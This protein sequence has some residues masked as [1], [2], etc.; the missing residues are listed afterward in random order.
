MKALI[1]GASSGIG[2]DMA[3]ILSRRGY[4]L[5]LVA[6]RRDRLEELQQQ[7]P[8][9]V[10]V[11][12]ADLSQEQACFDLYEQ[13]KNERIHILINNAGF[14]LF[15]SFAE[16]DLHR[17]LE[18]IDVNIRAVHI[19]TKLFV[20]DFIQRDSGYILNVSSSA[21]FLPGPL[22]SSYYASKA[23][24]LRL[25]Q[26]V[27]E[28]LRRRGSHVY[29]GALCPGPVKTEFDQVA[30]V[31]FSVKSMSSQRVAMIAIQQMFSRQPVI[32]PGA[33]MQAAKVLQKIVPDKLL[34]RISYHLQQR[35]QS[36]NLQKRKERRSSCAEEK[37]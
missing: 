10:T 35:K 9:N 21:A 11:I 7:L 20:R 4:D 37:I 28:E 26:A 18:L 16:T 22:L 29:I 31:H 12:C 17:E 32:I 24:V 1:T 25:T 6:R 19:L 30:D 5:I 14:G 34:V 23:Y 8:T 36:P 27:S 13:V 2:R 3:R 15:G 33:M